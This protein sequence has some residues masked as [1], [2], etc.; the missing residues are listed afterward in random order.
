MYLPNLIITKLNFKYV[1][2]GK[3]VKAVLTVTI[4]TRWSSLGCT[5]EIQPK[6]QG[7]GGRL[8]SFMMI[9]LQLR[10]SLQASSTSFFS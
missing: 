1:N 10:D 9:G 7:V 4:R 2:N 5:S 8:D 6:G 3:Y